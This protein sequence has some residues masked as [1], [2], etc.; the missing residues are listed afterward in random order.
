MVGVNNG[1]LFMESEIFKALAHPTRIRLI[2]HLG[3]HEKCVCEFAGDL[4]VEQ[5]NI[6]QHLAVLRKQGIVGF[7]KD[8]L[9]VMYK[10][11]YPQVFQMIE[12]VDRMLLLRAG[13][14]LS[15]LESE[16]PTK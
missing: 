15:S 4:N 5:S 2:K 10:I 14:T 12:L 13:E 9:R 8:G 6:S 16:I 11:N 3:E 1:L 7:R